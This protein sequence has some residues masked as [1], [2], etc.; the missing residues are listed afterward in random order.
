MVVFLPGQNYPQVYV[1]GIPVIIV[2]WQIIPYILQNIH[3][4]LVKSK[5]VPFG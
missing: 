4:G 3:P 2:L 5:N 1:T